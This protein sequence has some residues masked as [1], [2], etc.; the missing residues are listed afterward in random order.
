MNKLI[1]TKIDALRTN[2][3]DHVNPLKDSVRQVNGK[4]TLV[5]DVLGKMRN[6]VARINKL[7]DKM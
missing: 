2:L 6:E 3:F 1:D 4:I 5:D 7:R